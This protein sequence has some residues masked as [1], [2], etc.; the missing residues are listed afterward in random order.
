MPHGVPHRD[1]Q[2][3]AESA[4][5]RQIRTLTVR[6]RWGQDDTGSAVP[7]GAVLGGGRPVQIITRALRVRGGGLTARRTALG[8]ALAALL[9]VPLGS[10]AALAGARA[11]V[12]NDTP[13]IVVQPSTTQ[14][15][16]V[17]TPV[18]KVYVTEPHGK[19]PDPDF[20]G[21]VRLTYAVNRVGA[22]EPAGNVARAS[23]G[24]ATFPRLTFSAVGFG[25][26]LIASIKHEVNARP[27]AAFDIVTQLVHCPAGQSCKSE[28]VTAKGTSG[29][30]VASSGSS[31]GFLAATAGGFP[32]L[33]CTTRGGVLTFSASRAQLITITFPAKGRKGHHHLPRPWPHVCWG[34]PTPFVTVHGTTSKFNPANGDYEGVLPACGKHGKHGRKN[35]PPCELWRGFGF[36]HHLIARVLAPAGDPHI[37]F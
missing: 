16:R 14:A 3:R 6:L 25:F 10:A 7:A 15:G 8:A 22:P 1:V 9:I 33:S 17:M 34:A 18:V 24:V 37:T 28:K 32:A 20:D 35:K 21:R 5:R 13:V 2:R 30:S 19:R 31:S 23:H 29:S 27:S 36:G 12:D 4:F 26:K 11:D